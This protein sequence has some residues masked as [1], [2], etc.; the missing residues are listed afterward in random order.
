MLRFCC[1]IIIL[2][3]SIAYLINLFLFSNKLK[4]IGPLA[5]K[6]RDDNRLTFFWIPSLSF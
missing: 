5:I 2:N 3:G 4:K 6:Y 1:I